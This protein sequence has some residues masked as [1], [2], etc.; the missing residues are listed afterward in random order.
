[1]ELPFS[2]ACENNKLPILNELSRVF[3]ASRKVLEIGSG[4]G[5][6]AAFFAQEMPWLEWQPS[7]QEENLVHLEPRCRVAACEN[8]KS[9]IALDVTLMQWPQGFDAVFSA[10]TAHIMPWEVTQYAA[11][12]GFQVAPNGCVCLVWS[13]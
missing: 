12:S 3:R 8:L 2:Q 9:A 1:M 6:H 7:E 4:T 13:L 10:N 5:Q 11:R